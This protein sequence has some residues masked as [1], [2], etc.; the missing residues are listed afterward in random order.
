VNPENPPAFPVPDSVHL[1]GQVQF[2][3]N[4]MLLRDYFAAQVVSAIDQRSFK[5]TPDSIAEEAYL[6]ADAMLRARGGQTP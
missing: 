4:G 1:N 2:G 3:T 6:L 5:G